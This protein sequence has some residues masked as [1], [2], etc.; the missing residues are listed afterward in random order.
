MNLSWIDWTI[1]GASIVLVRLVSWKSASLMQG[2]ADFLSANRTAGRYLLTISGEMANFGVISLVAVWQAFNS[3]GFTI[4]WWGL[5]SAPVPIVLSLSGWVFYRLRETRTLTVGQFFEVRYSRKFRIFAGLLCWLSGILNFGIFP[6]IAAR[7]L[8]YF[9]GLPQEFVVPIIRLHISTY[10]ALMVADL[11]LALYFVA[12]GGQISIMIT[13]CVQGIIA[14]FAYL[15]V[16]VTVLVI[17][18]WHHAVTALQTAPASASMIDPFHT[19]QVK[20]FNAWYYIISIIVGTYGSQTWLGAQGFMTS[21]R[22]PHE[23]RMGSLISMWKQA[24]LALMTMLLPLAAFTVLHDQ[25]YAAKADLVHK[26]VAH[27]SNSSIRSEMIGPITIAHLLPTGIKGP[28]GNDLSFPVVYLSRHIHAFLGQHLCPGCGDAD[29][30]PLDE[31][32]TACH[33][34][35]M[36][37]SVCRGVRILFQHA[38]HRDKQGLLLPESSP[39][40]SGSAVP[41]R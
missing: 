18:P 19:G 30:K 1:I 41:D 25:S 4:V 13:E 36:V 40:P 12:S 35:P 16:A 15:A 38:L 31:S 24:P 34:A 26:I 7:M 29:Q 9:C 23:Q 17:I 8:I 6:A 20:D 27:I 21:A 14:S 11:G 37:D 2:V 5:M 39:A 22:N 3:A 32:R 33:M 10:P 28:A